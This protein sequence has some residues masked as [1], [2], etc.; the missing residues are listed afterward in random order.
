M[1]NPTLRLLV[2]GRSTVLL[3]VVLVAAACG[4]STPTGTPPP[5]S[6]GSSQGPGASPS[7]APSSGPT[8]GAIDHPTG[9]SD[10]ILRI[11]SGGG[12]VPIDFLATQAP[13]FTLY[14]NGV[15]VFQRQVTEFPQPDATGVTK[16]IP[17]RTATLDESQVQELLEFA[18]GQGGLGAARASYIDGGIAD[19]PDTIFTIH[20]GGVDKTTVVNALSEEPRPGPDTLARSAFFKLA[21][22]LQDFDQ[23]G[24][25]D[26]DVYAPERF[27][28]VL[29]EREP[30]AGLSPLDWPWTTIQLADFTAGPADGSGPTTFPHR[31]LT[32]DEVGALNVGAID[33]GLQGLAIQAPGGKLYNLVVRPLLADEKA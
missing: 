18:L 21:K 29:I 8:V 7:P 32:R 31:T 15:I 13:T 23:G 19:A 6:P 17:W 26:S 16:G 25:I 12:F 28:G 10:V 30:Q 9:A 11:E 27:R 14:G 5:A 3:L 4:N 1:P 33:G 24:T 20:A 2:A 22:R